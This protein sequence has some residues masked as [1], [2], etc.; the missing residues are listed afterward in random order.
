MLFTLLCDFYVYTIERS[1][2]WILTITNMP[3]SYVVI[4]AFVKPQFFPM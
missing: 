4:Q 3:N 2:Q 1:H